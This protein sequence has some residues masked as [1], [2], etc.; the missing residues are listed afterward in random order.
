MT[1]T[2]LA[3]T[4]ALVASV[5]ADGTA[6]V[7][8]LR[9]KQTCSTCPSSSPTAHPRPTATSGGVAVTLFGPGGR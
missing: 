7:I 6:A 2:E 4:A 9:G 3:A 1:L 8:T 5:P